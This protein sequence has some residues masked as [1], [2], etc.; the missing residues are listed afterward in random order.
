M[1]NRIFA[2]YPIPNKEELRRST[3]RF[4]KE[5]GNSF[6]EDLDFYIKGRIGDIVDSTEIILREKQRIEK[7]RK[8]IGIAVNLITEGASPQVKDISKKYYDDILIY[9]ISE[10]GSRV[11]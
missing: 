1:K 7:A 5:T 10:T 4:S 8:V 3:E 2:R 6:K 11:R 9:Q